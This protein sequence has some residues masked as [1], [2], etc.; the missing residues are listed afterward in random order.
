MDL[1]SQI[2]HLQEELQSVPSK[3]ATA[4]NEFLPRPPE[5]F[6]MNGHR[7]PITSA[8]F[9]PVFSSLASASE[10]CTVKIWDFD[11]GDLEKTLKGH[12]KAVFC[13]DYDQKGNILGTNE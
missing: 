3:R 11:S 5:K 1:E 10:D 13:I 2:A 6:T 9:H 8:V 12:T 7:S 4:G